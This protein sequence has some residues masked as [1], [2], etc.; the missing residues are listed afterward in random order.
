MKVGMCVT[1]KSHQHDILFRVKQIENNRAILQ[2]EVIRLIADAPIED[3]VVRDEK[4]AKLILPRL[5]IGNQMRGKI[6]TGLV[7]HVDGDEHYLKKAMIAYKEYGISAIGYYV[8]EKEL[9][10]RIGNLLK[11]HHPDIV[12]LTGHDALDGQDKNDARSYR[13][14]KDFMEAVHV[15]RDY[16]S[17]KD[18]L[19]I[20]AGACQSYYEGLL[21]A[22]ANFASSPTRENIHL[23]DPVLIA[24]QIAQTEV[25]EY[26]SI[27]EILRRTISHRL[28][29]IETKGVARKSYIGGAET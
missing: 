1:R 3:L 22:G 19:V 24:A 29:G 26:A 25:H 21:Q 7:L 14:S 12:V 10:Y 17:N 11:K 15:A 9:P 5:P 16:Q 2:G 20:I 6:I 8:K 23:L 13:T 28:G 18:A 4:E 27:H